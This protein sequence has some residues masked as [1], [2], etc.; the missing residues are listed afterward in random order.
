ME[1]NDLETFLKENPCAKEFTPY[2][3]EDNGI[4]TIY[5]KDDPDYS[6]QLADQVVLFR[7]I[8]TN[9]IIGCKILSS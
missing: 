5:L 9:E 8:E 2:C 3:H 1:T 7:S 6:E 4:I